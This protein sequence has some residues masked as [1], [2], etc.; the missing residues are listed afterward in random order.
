[1]RDGHEMA[2][3]FKLGPFSQTWTAVIEENQPEYFV[4]TQTHGPMSYW[5]HKHSFK[6]VPEGTELTD[7]VRFRMPLGPLGQMA[8][9]LFAKESIRRLFLYRNHMLEIR[10]GTPQEASP[11]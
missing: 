2:F 1:M 11:S 5:H 7:E 3:R 4:D 6:E 10:F 9:K 8:F